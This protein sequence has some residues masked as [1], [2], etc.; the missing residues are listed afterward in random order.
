[1]GVLWGMETKA[2]SAG[3]VR[4]IGITLG[5]GLI[6][7]S[8]IIYAAAKGH[9]REPIPEAGDS[10]RTQILAHATWPPEYSLPD[11]V[12]YAKQA[13]VIA[14]IRV[15]DSGREGEEREAGARKGIPYTDWRCVVINSIKGP[16]NPG[17]TMIIRQT[18]SRSTFQLDDDP[19]FQPGSVEL[20]FLKAFS[21]GKY[22]DMGPFSRM[23][24]DEKQGVIRQGQLQGHTI[25]SAASMIRSAIGLSPDWEMK[26]GGDP[27]LTR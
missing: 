18:G 24:V 1:M 26:G 7:L 10:P 2:H 19:L 4:T 9:D 20:V 25:E 15:M 17:E 14:V 16:L 11:F 27:Y 21:P 5:G 6:L 23:A 3:I 8:L 13:D 12:S 22:R